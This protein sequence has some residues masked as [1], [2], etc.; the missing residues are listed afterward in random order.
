MNVKRLGNKTAYCALLSA[1][2]C[3]L[4]SC[5]AVDRTGVGSGYI[6][7]DLQ[8]LLDRPADFDLQDV[9]TSGFLLWHPDEPVLFES[10]SAYK[11]LEFDLSVPL[12]NSSD[13]EMSSGDRRL[14]TIAGRFHV[15]DHIPT[16][17]YPG[18]I[19]VHSMARV[20]ARSGEASDQ[21]H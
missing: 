19:R 4:A 13:I 18:F 5:G 20:S 10:E 12:E 2:C 1:L 21:A 6:E 3:L 16:D 7:V 11:A 8:D 17:E 15:M 14:V 9:S